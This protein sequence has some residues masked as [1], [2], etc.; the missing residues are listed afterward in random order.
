MNLPDSGWMKALELRITTTLAIGVMGTGVY[1]LAEREIAHLDL[2]PNWVRATAFVIGAGALL[3]SAGHVV[4]NILAHSQKRRARRK[5]EQRVLAQLDTLSPDEQAI[6]ARQLYHGEQ[7][8]LA[9][10]LEMPVHLLTTR[11]L[12]AQ[13]TGYHSQLSWPH[14]IPD[15]VWLEMQLR[16][17]QIL[18]EHG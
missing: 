11:G 18:G 13:A 7:A 14:L 6:L 10:I 2:F 12:V 3:L 15:F 16:R 1:L 5:Y 4:S 8:F 9:S 17:H